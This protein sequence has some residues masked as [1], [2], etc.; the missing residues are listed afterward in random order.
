MSAEHL[1]FCIKNYV[2]EYYQSQLLLH[3]CISL[4]ISDQHWS[5]PQVGFFKLNVDGALDLRDGLQGVG[6]IVRDSHD[7]LIGAVAMRAPSH[8]FVLAIE[9]Y[10]FKVV[11][12]NSLAAVQL[13]SK[14]EECLAPKGVL[15]TEIRRLL[16]A[17]SSCVRF[18]PRSANIVA[19]RCLVHRICYFILTWLP[20][21]KLQ[22]SE[23]CRTSYFEILR[24][25][26]S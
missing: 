15:V 7:V 5:P 19:H 14:E 21:Q 2:A 3:R 23:N 20:N 26:T 1:L 8:L 16:P 6:L 18:I 13:L 22:H 24:S 9:I 25:E 4:P 12:S 11:E 10:A 17:L